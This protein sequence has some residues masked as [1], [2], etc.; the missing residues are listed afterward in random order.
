MIYY[1]YIEIF[2]KTF[3]A[4]LFIVTAIAR[5]KEIDPIGLS[6]NIEYSR[7]YKFKIYTQYVQVL[8]EISI[9][10]LYFVEPLI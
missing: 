5:Y 6:K 9:I 4:A 2:C 10:T 7:L 1:F 8:T 3:P